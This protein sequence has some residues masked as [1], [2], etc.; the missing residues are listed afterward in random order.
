MKRSFW[1]I[2]VF[3]FPLVGCSV[4]APSDT[5]HIIIS[6]NPTGANLT[7]CNQSTSLCVSNTKTPSKM[8]LSRSQDIF[9]PQ[10]YTILCTKKGFVDVAR[11]LHFG[12]DGWYLLIVDEATSETFEV[13][14]VDGYKIELELPKSETIETN[15]GEEVAK[16]NMANKKDQKRFRNWCIV[17]NCRMNI[18]HC[19][20]LR[21][22]FG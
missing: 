17:V 3:Y 21:N 5:F 20:P 10:S 19:R 7:V 11:T 14:N 6:T 13:R 1:L 16:L 18:I 9:W 8:I 4:K 22:A 2:F 15:P 12:I